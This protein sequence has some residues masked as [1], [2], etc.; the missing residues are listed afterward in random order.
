MD[1]FYNKYFRLINGYVRKQIDDDEIAPELTNTILLSAW[2][3]LPYYEG[4]ASQKN[5]IMGIAKHKISDF[6]RKKKIKTV[7]FSAIPRLEDIADKSI[8]PEG[9]SLKTELKQEIKEVLDEL[10]EGYSKI[11]RLKYIEGL[12]NTEIAKKLSQSYKAVESKLARARAKFR[13][14]YERKNN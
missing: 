11:L 5:W 7:L 3:S 9:E 2:N 6:F 13:K 10:S 4:K 14:I 12:R 8:G 1:E